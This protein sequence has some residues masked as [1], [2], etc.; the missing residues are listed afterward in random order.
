MP[1]T[2]VGFDTEA[3]R[4]QKTESPCSRLFVS[5][6]AVASGL[7]HVDGGMG[8]GRGQVGQGGQS[9]SVQRGAVLTAALSGPS[10]SVSV[11]AISG[12]ALESG[13]GHIGPGPM[14]WSNVSW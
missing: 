11:R 6:D 5:E 7:R 1:D 9:T 3:E 14:F 12:R 2:F 13:Q 8:F 10:V 4:F